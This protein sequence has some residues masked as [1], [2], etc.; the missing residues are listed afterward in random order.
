M[1]L[2]SEVVRGI[3]PQERYRGVL[4]VGRRGPILELGLLLLLQLVLQEALWGTPYMAR[5]HL[6]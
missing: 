3:L 6:R 2:A 1:G 5:H 4:E